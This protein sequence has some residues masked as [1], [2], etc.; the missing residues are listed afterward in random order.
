MKCLAKY[1]EVSGVI[2]VLSDCFENVSHVKSLRRVSSMILNVEHNNIL[3][4]S[5]NVYNTNLTNRI[6]IPLKVC[7]KWS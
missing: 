3:N 1:G 7:F 4:Y 5:F 6:F 2:Q